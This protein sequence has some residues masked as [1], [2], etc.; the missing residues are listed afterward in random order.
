MKTYNITNDFIPT[1]LSLMIKEKSKYI[2][3]SNYDL[4]F[5][6]TNLRLKSNVSFSLET[7]KLRVKTG[8][9][10]RNPKD[11]DKFIDT[12]IESTLIVDSRLRPRVVIFDQPYAYSEYVEEGL[13]RL[14]EKP[15]QTQSLEDLTTE[16]SY[17]F[18]LLETESL[19]IFITLT[20]QDLKVLT[21]QNLK[22]LEFP[23]YD[24]NLSEI[25]QTQSGQNIELTYYN[26]NLLSPLLVKGFEKQS[27]SRVYK[28]N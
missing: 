24:F 25:L 22:P 21:S 14:V 20:T 23:T 6:R 1:L 13:D 9:R 16:G 3:V 15:L 5:L 27:Y 11:F 8:N 19:K 28:L 10:I 7:N 2:K 4:A 26:R 17:D 18:D 12:Y